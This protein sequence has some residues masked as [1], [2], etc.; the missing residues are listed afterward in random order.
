MT[1]GTPHMLLHN[2]A[3]TVAVAARSKGSACG[4]SL[5]EIVGSDPAEGMDICPLCVLYFVR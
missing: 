3:C 5:A 1:V 2:L 4:R